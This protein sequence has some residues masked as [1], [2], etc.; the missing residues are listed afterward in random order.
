MN[1]PG[2][3]ALLLESM[4]SKLAAIPRSRKR[5]AGARQPRRFDPAKAG[6]LD[7]PGR[8]RDLPPREVM[9]LLAPPREGLVVDFGSGTGTYALALA[10]L[11]P[12]IEIAAFDEQDAMLALLKDKLRA[13]PPAAVKP[14]KAGAR[15]VKALSGRVDRVLAINVLHELG[16]RSLEDLS[17]LLKKDGKALFIDWSADV[18]RPTPPPREHV[19]SPGEA[20]KKLEGFGFRIEKR[21]LFRWQYAFLCRLDQ[22]LGSA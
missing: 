19:Y 6:F 8:F 15:S 5:R 7:D 11:R 18:D 9:R 1:N 17:S 13:G 4:H 3:K 20:E 21:R 16:D 22:P 2:R 12:D 14:I 10:R